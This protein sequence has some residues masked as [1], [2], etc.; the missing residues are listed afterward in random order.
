MSFQNQQ[1]QTD[2]PG[3]R[4]LLSSRSNS[5][6]VFCHLKQTITTPAKET[7]PAFIP[8]VSAFITIAMPVC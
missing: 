2:V 3:V 8:F 7:M 1:R 6:L 4:E 5:R